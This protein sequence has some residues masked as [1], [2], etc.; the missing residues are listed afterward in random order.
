MTEH[1]CYW[2]TAS[3]P[4]WANRFCAIRRGMKFKR[5]HWWCWLHARR[6]KDDPAP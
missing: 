6:I 4:D 5:G 1:T 2:R 3:R